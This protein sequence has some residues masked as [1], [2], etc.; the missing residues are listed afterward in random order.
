MLPWNK[1]ITRE[2]KG[3]TKGDEERGGVVEDECRTC[4]GKD[5][6]MTACETE[7]V[8]DGGGRGM[9]TGGIQE[10]LRVEI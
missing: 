9:G 3:P 8:R 7:G 5:R 1:S 10:E 6:G 4:E 2:G